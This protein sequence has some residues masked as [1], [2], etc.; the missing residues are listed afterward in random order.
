M[1]KFRLFG[2]IQNLLVILLKYL[3]NIL[4][5]LYSMF[6]DFIWSYPDPLVG[7]EPFDRILRVSCG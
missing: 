1:L 4:Y 6:Y 7:S 3:F 5:F 2:F